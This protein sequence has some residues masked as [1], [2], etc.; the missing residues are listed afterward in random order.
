MI[1]V[2]GTPVRAGTSAADG[3]AIIGAAEQFVPRIFRDAARRAGHDPATLALGINS[4]GYVADTSQQARDEFFPSYAYA[5]TAIGRE[6]GWPPLTRAAFDTSCSLRGALFVGS[7]QDVIE[8]IRYQRELFGHQRFLMQMSV[9]TMPHA[10]VKRS[11]EL[12]ATSV[13]PEI[14]RSLMPAAC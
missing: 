4:H 14:R 2:G 11:I 6:R 10:H 7:P 3:L 12:F 5:M 1:A 13:A 9:G 8:K